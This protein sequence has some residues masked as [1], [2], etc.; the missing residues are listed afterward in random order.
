MFLPVLLVRDFGLAGFV[1]FAVP[2]VVGAAAMGWATR[3]AEASGR[4]L[5]EHATATR[6]FSIVTI[7]FHGF[8]LAWLARS[9]WGITLPTIGV[10]LAAFAASALLGLRTLGQQRWIGVCLFVVTV[11]AGTIAAS[12]WGWPVLAG[13]MSSGGAALPREHAV[14]LA[15]VC[16]LGFGLCPYLDLTFHRA[17][18]ELSRGGAR[19]AF[20]LGFGVAFLAMILLTLAY[21]RVFL[22]DDG[23]G[24]APRA[25]PWLLSAHIVVQSVF[26]VG[27]HLRELG[28]HPAPEG[29]STGGCLAACAIFVL[30]LLGAI[31]LGMAVEPMQSAADATRLG[32]GEIAYRCFMSAYGLAFP[33]YVWTCIVPRGKWAVAPR[34]A[35]VAWLASVVAAS[36]CLAMGFLAR[37][38]WWLVPGVGIVLV[39]PIVARL[40]SGGRR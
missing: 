19:A 37:E 17:R 31:G 1:A 34:T 21:N 9:W 8:F 39:A 18:R 14:P 32:T 10:G 2:N 4:M 35:R 23:L 3:D 15:A 36:P 25:L 38:T 5:I 26:T 6:L 27:V 22:G 20:G 13:G 40:V 28:R 24:V 11:V 16:V 30:A 29:I 33:A 7:L 12:R